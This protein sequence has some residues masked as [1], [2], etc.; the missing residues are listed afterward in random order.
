MQTTGYC[1][2]LAFAT[3]KDFTTAINQEPLQA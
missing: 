2:L 3:L 1:F